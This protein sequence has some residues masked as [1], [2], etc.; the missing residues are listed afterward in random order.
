MEITRELLK[1]ALES[2]LLA[3]DASEAAVRALVREAVE[4]GFAGVCVPPHLVCAAVEE[5][6]GTP[7]SVVSVV[8][9]P[10]GF[11][12]VETKATEISH[13][14]SVGADEVDAVV[15]QACVKEMDGPKLSRE[16]KTLREAAKGAVLKIILETG[17]HEPA[18]LH[19]AARIAVDEGADFLKTS[20]GIGVR[21][22][23]PEDVHF[24]K[25]I[26]GTKAGVKASGGIRTPA[27]ATALINAGAD[28]LG[29]SA[30]AAI[31]RE[32]K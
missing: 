4:L 32:F 7:L 19:L 12:C 6:L 13:L 11:E 25:K 14:L 17:R 23:T 10:L 26:A 21:G 8:A 30:A 3:P 28:R 1:N 2:T 20:T 27:D 5:A 24:L 31:W 22:A 29:T 16:L 18:A 9:F 15:N